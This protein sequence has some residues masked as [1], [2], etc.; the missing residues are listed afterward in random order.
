MLY[1]MLIFTSVHGS[2]V[3]DGVEFF[4]D[5]SLDGAHFLLHMILAILSM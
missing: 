4:R 3:I 2:I 5:C 1:L